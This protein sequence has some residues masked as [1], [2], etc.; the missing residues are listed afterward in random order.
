MA[1]CGLLVVPTHVGGHIEF[2]AAGIG[3]LS[4]RWIEASAVFPLEVIVG[5]ARRNL[6]RTARVRFFYDSL[7]FSMTLCLRD[8]HNRWNIPIAHRVPPVR[9]CRRAAA[10]APQPIARGF[11]DAPIRPVGVAVLS[12]AAFALALTR[13]SV[14]PSN[15]A[16]PPR[17]RHSRLRGSRSLRIRPRRTSSRRLRSSCRRASS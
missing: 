8:L 10:S 17:R 15:R 6:N 4:S 16:G 13:I 11:H 12:S 1:A 3:C 14:S 7:L 2:V 5:S 9:H